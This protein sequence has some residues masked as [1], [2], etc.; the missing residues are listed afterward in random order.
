MDEDGERLVPA[1]VKGCWA[2]TKDP[3]RPGRYALV[4]RVSGATAGYGLTELSA[5]EMAT[6][7][8]R[9]GIPWALLHDRNGNDLKT[10]AWAQARRLGEKL[11]KEYVATE[12]GGTARVRLVANPG[13]KQHPEL[14]M[15]FGV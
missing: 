8:E 12:T 15:M 6:E 4:H 10:E 13:P 2:V 3:V 14:V 11:F 1:T 7:L 9:G 5:K